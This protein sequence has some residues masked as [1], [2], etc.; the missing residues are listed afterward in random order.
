[1]KLEFKILEDAD[2]VDTIV[3]DRQKNIDAIADIM[4]D[5]KEITTDFVT[6]VDAQGTKLEDLENNM[7][8]VANNATEATKQLKKANERSK[9]NG[10]CLLIIVAVLLCGLGIL[11]AILFGTGAI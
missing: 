8:D 1:M 6:E 4:N 11:L 3:R 9:S 10:K 2:V 7:E 5:I